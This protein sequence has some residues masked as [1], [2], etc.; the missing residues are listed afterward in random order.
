[1]RGGGAV[2]MTSAMAPVMGQTAGDE[3]V[4]DKVGSPDTAYGWC[5]VC[6]RFTEFPHDCRDDGR[7][8]GAEGTMTT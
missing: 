3:P 2:P 6:H 4:P 8:D 1:M 7:P 5:G